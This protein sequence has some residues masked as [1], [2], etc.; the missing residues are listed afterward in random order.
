VGINDQMNS[1]QNHNEKRN[2]RIKNNALASKNEE[3]IK[4]SVK[5]FTIKIGRGIVDVKQITE[6][7]YQVW[8]G[9][10]LLGTVQRESHEGGTHWAS[11]TNID[12]S[13]V[14]LIGIGILEYEATRTS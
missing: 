6:S 1:E 12:A 10:V 11:P 4:N 2:D 9:D 3:R 13:L 8:I 14:N 7:S 5:D